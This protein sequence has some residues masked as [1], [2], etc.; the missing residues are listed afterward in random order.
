M[1]VEFLSPEEVQKDSRGF[2]GKKITPA[3]TVPDPI[4]VD[5]KPLNFVSAK[6][7]LTVLSNFVGGKS[8]YGDLSPFTLPVKYTTP[9]GRHCLAF[10]YYVGD[11]ISGDSRYFKFF[12]PRSEGK[13]LEDMIY[14]VPHRHIT[15][16][17]AP[18]Y[19]LDFYASPRN[20]AHILTSGHL[21]LA[22]GNTKVKFQGWHGLEEQLLVDYVRGINN[23]SFEDLLPFSLIGID[24]SHLKDYRLAG[25]AQFSIKI[26]KNKNI[27]DGDD[28]RLVPRT[29]DQRLYEWV[30]I[31]KID[32]LLPEHR[33]PLI[34]SYRILV[35]ESR[36]YSR[37]WFEPEKQLL[38]D[39]M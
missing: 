16:G 33:W 2:R 3:R 26:D 18:Y 25:M 32:P 39:H 14:I 1:K 11:N 12:L 7:G 27:Q 30:D 15:R 13:F 6:E 22:E 31:L 5:P 20:D 36:I 4:P 9:Q 34:C 37:G 21:S 10:S 23:L 38:L 8:K 19:W 29:D 17:L 35:T 28:L 24:K